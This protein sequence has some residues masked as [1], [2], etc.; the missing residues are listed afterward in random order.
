MIADAA[1]ATR[2]DVDLGVMYTFTYETQYMTRLL[3]SLRDSIG[4][5]RAR[6][7]LV[8]NNPGDSVEPWQDIF[9]ATRVLQN[10]RRLGYATVLNRILHTSSAR[11]TLLLNTDMYFNP[12][13]QCVLRM[14][15]FMDSHPDCGLSGCGLYHG[16]GTFAY[17]ARRFQTLPILAARRLGLGRWMPQTLNDY[18]YRQNPP[19]GTWNCDWLSGCFHMIRREA[20]REVGD[21]DDTFPK[22]FEDVDMGLRMARAGW[23]VMYYGGTYGYHLERRDS[24]RLFTRDAWQHLQSYFRWHRKWGFSYRPELPERPQLRKA[25]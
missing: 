5:L 4:D 10:E 11:Y 3:E 25:A 18:L 22:Y 8:H 23:R 13:A 9:P 20:Y 7:I 19:E 16:D 12:E 15:R 6:L 24:K 1:T 14:V 21:Y 2:F 17:P